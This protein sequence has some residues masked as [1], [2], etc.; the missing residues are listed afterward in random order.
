MGRELTP[1]QPDWDLIK[2]QSFDPQPVIIHPDE[3]DDFLKEH[4]LH[5]GFQ[6]NDGIKKCL[7]LGLIKIWADDPGFD[8]RRQVQSNNI[9]L[10]LGNEFWF[11]KPHKISRLTL[12]REDVIRELDLLEYAYKLDGDEFVFHPSRLVL[13]MTKDGVAVSNVAAAEFDGVSKLGRHGISNHQ[14]AGLIHSGFAGH[15]MAELSNVN[16]LDVAVPIGYKIGTLKV[17]LTADP[18]T[19]PRSLDPDKGWTNLQT[20]PFGFRNPKWDE[21]RENVIRA[22]LVLANGFHLTGDGAKLVV[23]H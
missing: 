10:R 12:G 22:G 3:Y 4:G 5:R 15:I 19:E 2:E 6:T 14:T 20:G 1:Y 9:D 8:L 17:T 11:F 13:A 18:C 7:E 23:S 16:D 21:E